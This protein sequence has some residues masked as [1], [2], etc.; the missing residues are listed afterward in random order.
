MG[1]HNRLGHTHNRN[2]ERV[3]EGGTVQSLYSKA[4]A[5][6]EEWPTNLK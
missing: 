5:N 4:E 3:S 1:K 2:H 6:T